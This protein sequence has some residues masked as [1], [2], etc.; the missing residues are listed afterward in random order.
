MSTHSNLDASS[1]NATPLSLAEARARVLADESLPLP[2]RR[3]MASALSSVAKAIGRPPETIAATPSVL[4]PLLAG[5][6]P[7]MV[8][9]RPGRWRN[10]RSLVSR[11]LAHLDIILVQGRIC[12]A[13]SPAWQTILRPLGKG[14]GAARHFHLWRFARY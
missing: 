4:R 9:C 7:A 11:T 14:T 13:P 12:E 2:L 1:D 8:G 3:D 10:I 6:T 5:L